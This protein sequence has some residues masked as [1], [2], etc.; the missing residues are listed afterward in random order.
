MSVKLVRKIIRESLSGRIKEEVFSKIEHG[1]PEKNGYNDV[2]FYVGRQ[3]IGYIEYYYDG[4]AMS[5][6][7]PES[8]KEFYISMIEVYE[9]HRGNQYVD[10]M[11]DEIKKIAK[12]LGATIIT[13]RVDYGM[14]YGSSNREPSGK[15][16]R[17]YLRN[18]F[19]YTFSEKESSEND[20]KDIGAM[21]Y[22]IKN[23][24]LNE[25]HKFYANQNPDLENFRR[26]CIDELKNKGKQIKLVVSE[27]LDKPISNIGV[28]IFG[29]VID[30]NKFSNISDVD[31][32]IYIKDEVNKIVGTNEEDSYKVQN[33][34]LH[35]FSFGALNTTVI[36]NELP[37]EGEIKI[38]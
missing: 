16:D 4:T 11:L 7:I 19:E 28:Y 36:Y 37:K 3:K 13:L 29:S 21:Y 31:V 9:K 10:K 25:G 33:E 32:V 27:V 17:I 18:G 34:F 15:L 22:R 35:G 6:H 20:E 23:A 2:F 5:L 12:N 1:K 26:K 24:P 8:E 30:T 38:A 14:G